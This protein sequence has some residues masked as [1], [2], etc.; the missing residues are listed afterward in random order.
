MLCQTSYTQSV[1]YYEKANFVYI[2]FSLKYVYS[3]GEKISLK[4]MT[5]KKYKKITNYKKEQFI[6][7]NLE[8]AVSEKF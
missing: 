5:I 4:N 2:V 7:N 6:K 8:L 3:D 1:Q